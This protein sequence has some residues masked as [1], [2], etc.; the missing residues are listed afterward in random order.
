MRDPGNEVALR[1]DRI[2]WFSSGYTCDT[3]LIWLAFE[4]SLRWRKVGAA[5]NYRTTTVVDIQ[6]N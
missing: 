3:F 6:L 5:L 4:L 2:G 1:R